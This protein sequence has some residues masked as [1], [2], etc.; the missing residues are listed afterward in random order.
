[1]ELECLICAKHRGAG[2]LVGPILYTDDLVVVSHRPLTEGAPVPGYLFV[3]SRRHA[4]TVADLTDSEAAAIGWAVRRCAH[5][6][7]HELEPEFVFSAIAGRSVDH[8]HQHVF[9]RPTG[10]PA[11]IHW[12]DV[13]SWSDGPRIDAAG[14][15]RL[16]ARLSAHFVDPTGDAR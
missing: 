10:T 6:L 3:E 2:R 7:R 1:M 8:F 13:D 5:A 15:T 16:A 12:F 9:A 14:L 11:T 4:P